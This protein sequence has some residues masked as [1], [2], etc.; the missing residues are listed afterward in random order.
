M[1]SSLEDTVFPNVFLIICM[2]HRFWCSFNCVSV[3]LKSV[4]IHILNVLSHSYNKPY[5]YNIMSNLNFSF[6]NLLN[7]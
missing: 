1:C 4:F 6:K 3:H 2:P 7:I 5:T